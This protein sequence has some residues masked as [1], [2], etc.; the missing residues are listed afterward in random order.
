[1]TILSKGLYLLKK[2]HHSLITFQNQKTPGSEVFTGELHNTLTE[3]I[4][5]F[6]FTIFQKIGARR[7]C[8]DSFYEVCITLTLKP[9]KNIAK[10]KL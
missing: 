3:E 6:L 9:D 4:I 2:S 1:V 10:R 8:P 5:P 7:L